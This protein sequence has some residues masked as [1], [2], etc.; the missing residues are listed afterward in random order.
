MLGD[1]IDGVDRV[2]F[3]VAG[4][5]RQRFERRLVRR[6]RRHRRGCAG[7]ATGS[8][9]RAG[10]SRDFRRLVVQ[11]AGGHELRGLLF[12]ARV[13]EEITAAD[14]GAGQVFQQVGPAQRRMKFDVEVKAPAVVLVHRR[15]VQRHHVG[16][17]HPPEIVEAN[18]DIAQHRCQI[19]TLT[20]IEVG[21]GRHAP[22]GRDVDFVRVARKIRHEGNRAPL[23]AD[24]AAAVL[25]LGGEDVLEE[26]AAGFRQMAIAG[27]QLGLDVLE[28]EVRGVD[29]AMR[30][31]VADPDRLTLVLEDQHE[32]DVGMR[33][34]ARASVPARSR[35][36]RRRRRRRA[37]RASHRGA[38]CSRPRAR[39]RWRDALR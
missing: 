17:R 5:V 12:R 16:E 38:G 37:R 18:H 23:L 7:A 2:A 29:L 31:R 1:A 27:A 6:R 35:A 19:A 14:L 22:R 11:S 25:A 28:D 15:L 13:A 8:D 30:V 4:H 20:V 24:D 21:D 10:A 33:R 26:H 39:R 36:A 34:R 32:L 3:L 9:R